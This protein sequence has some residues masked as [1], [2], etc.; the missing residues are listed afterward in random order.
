[1]AL[2]PEDIEAFRITGFD[3]DAASSTAVFRYALDDVAA[4][5][6]RIEFAAEG[7]RPLALSPDQERGL[8]DCLRLL[9]LAAGVSY[10]KAAAPSRIIVTSPLTAGERR[11]CRD[12]YDHGLREFAYRNG[13]E[14]PRRFEIDAPPSAGDRGPTAPPAPGLGIPV[15]GGKD[16]ITVV[17]ALRH[18]RPLLVSVNGHP[19]ARR[20]AAVAGL[21]LAVI[22]RTI[23]PELLELNRAGA[24]NGHVP[25][26]AIV[27]LIT[28]AAGFLFGYDTTVM[29]L[30]SSADD[31]TRAAATDGATVGAT[32]ES[33]AAVP[34]E[35]NHQW[36]KSLAF[37]RELQETL[38]QSVHPGVRYLSALRDVSDLQIAASFAG[39]TRYHPVFR[40]CN[41]AFGLHST[42][43]GWC[44]QCPKCRFVYLTLATALGPPE[45]V[46]IFGGDMLADAAQTEGFRDLLEEGR[47]PFECVGTRQES[48]LA[49]RRLRRDPRWRD[50]PVLVA[51]GPVIESLD[52]AGAEPGPSRADTVRDA[53]RPDAVQD[54]VRRAVG[55]SEPAAVGE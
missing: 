19:A 4:F 36:S 32:D 16:S 51:L 42:F 2:R 13:L 7:R 38:R 23:S 10:Y 55:A 20:V 6:E 27:S 40:S 1:M 26:T 3:F 48:L 54:A 24:R 22:R 44:R 41:R 9:H 33:S 53:V 31:P 52:D 12:L 5:E 28:V 14:V 43:D 8:A 17:D 25:V 50:A 11:F 49:F 34:V 21:E 29:A 46:A 18:L 35:V 47:K 15:G 30:E 39:L 37:E 45:L